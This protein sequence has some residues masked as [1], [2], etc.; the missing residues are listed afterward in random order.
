MGTL[1]QSLSEVK[2][3]V[4]QILGRYSGEGILGCGN[5][6]CKGPVA[7]SGLEWLQQSE[8]GGGEGEAGRAPVVQGLRSRCRVSS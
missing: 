8:A 7:G 6:Q 4:V 2:E 5:S 3:Q 1:E